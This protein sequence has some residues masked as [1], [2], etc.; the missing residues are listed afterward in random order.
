MKKAEDK[1]VIVVKH[2]EIS[3]NVIEV[4]PCAVENLLEYLN[5]R[6]LCKAAYNLESDGLIDLQLVRSISSQRIKSY[7]DLMQK[8][9]PNVLPLISGAWLVYKNRKLIYDFNQ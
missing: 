4:P 2:D 6:M 1:F 9:S 7:G 3:N 8:L 5:L